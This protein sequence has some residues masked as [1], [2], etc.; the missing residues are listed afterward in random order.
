[1][2]VTLYHAKHSLWSHYLRNALQY[3][4]VLVYVPV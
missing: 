3:L 4:Q 2:K 1:M